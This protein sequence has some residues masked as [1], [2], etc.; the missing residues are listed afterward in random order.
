MF[1]S[2]LPTE[3]STSTAWKAPHLPEMWRRKESEIPPPF[4]RTQ[5]GRPLLAVDHGAVESMETRKNGTR[6][7]PTEQSNG[8]GEG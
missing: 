2:T 1:N 5:G 8:R 3:A 6:M 7:N 4:S